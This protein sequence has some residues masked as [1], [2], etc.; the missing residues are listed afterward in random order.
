[1]CEE[2][3]RETDRRRDDLTGEHR[4]VRELFI[5]GRRSRGKRPLL[6]TYVYIIQTKNL[7]WN[8]IT[9]YGSHWTVETY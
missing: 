4:E 9:R 5:Y 1:M 3:K 2:E 8:M 7:F 6:C